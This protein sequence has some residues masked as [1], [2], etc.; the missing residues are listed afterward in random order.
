[1]LKK[2]ALRELV[3]EENP[4]EELI[5]NNLLKNNLDKLAFL[6]NYNM[7]PKDFN[8]LSLKFLKIRAQHQF[9]KAEQRAFEKDASGNK[10]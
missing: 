10:S 9:N 3:W 5:K 8:K 4:P 7:H 6:E 2:A 1:M